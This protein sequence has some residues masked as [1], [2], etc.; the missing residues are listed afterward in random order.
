[1]SVVAYVGIGSNAGDP[2]FNVRRAAFALRAAGCVRRLSSLRETAPWG[3][4]A[5]RR[6]VNAVAC[7]ETAL[8][9]R[10]LLDVLQGI[11]RRLG[12]RASYHW[13][14][15]VIDLDLL[16]YDGLRID[17]P[18]L[19]VPHPLMFERAFVMEPL[20]EVGALSRGRRI[21]SR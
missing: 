5:Q 11:E 1:M 14:P 21:A 18:G 16:L 4:V 13:G 6:F 2:A 3:R 20:A 10:V 15:R 12:R 17:E 8:A 19:V 9:P 7:L